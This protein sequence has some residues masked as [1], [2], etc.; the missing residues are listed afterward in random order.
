MPTKN[1]SC[2]TAGFTL[3]ELMITVA[4]IALIAGFTFAEINSSSYK[5]KSA[6][7]NLKTAMQQA[8]L[9]AIKINDIV[10]I[11]F[12]HNQDG[13]IDTDGYIVI[14]QTSGKIYQKTITPKIT[15]SAPSGG[16]IQFTAAGNSYSKTLTLTNK[17]QTEPEYKITVHSTGRIELEKTK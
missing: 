3:V 13:T 14:E 11:D 9:G 7:R 17:D 15:F 2:P 12:D 1:S 5:L 4:I 6:A 10:N 8:R 16:I